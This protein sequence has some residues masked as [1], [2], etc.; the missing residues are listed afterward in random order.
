MTKNLARRAG[1][2]LIW[3]GLAEAAE[4]TIFLARLFILARL[5]APE[6]F[7]L[8]AV[9]MVA[10]AMVLRL[11]DFGVVASLIHAPE[12][13]QRHLDTAWTISL[14][15]GI[16]IA[17]I[18]LL[19][20]PWIADAFGEP[21]ATDIIRA[22]SLTALLQA[23]ASIQVAKLNREL[24]FRGLAVIRLS[25]AIANTIVAIFLA[26]SLGVWAMVWGAIA[27]EFAFMLVSYFVAPYR[28]RFSMSDQATK[29]I[30]RFGRW[31]F[32]IGIISVAADSVIR[33]I[34]SSRLGIAELGLY[35]MAWRLAYLPV[36]LISELVNEV[37]FPVYAQLQSNRDKAAAAFRGLLV[38]VAAIMVPTCVVF[39]W[40]VPEL[41]QYV[42]GERWQGTVEVMQLL[43]MT[44]IVMLLADGMVPVLKGLGQPSKIAAMDT[45]QLVILAALGWW[46]IGAWE[47]PGAGIAWMISILAA[48]VM[49]ARYA[50]EVFRTPFAGLLRPL[51]AIAAVSILAAIVAEAAKGLIPGLIGLGVAIIAA[52]LTAGA[53]TLLLDRMFSLGILQTVLVPFPW[54]RRLVSVPGEREP[55]R[56]G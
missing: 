43:I 30:A 20:A 46:L 41:V 49:A 17:A 23:A 8:L 25:A 55:R 54:I 21:R 6:D 29:S 15:R 35:F 13:G 2:G 56:E 31:I 50:Y 48:Q 38:S 36:Q 10:L 5:L 16:G 26:P 1:G 14:L 7:G 34:I 39:A 37:A 24:R 53:G 11:T 32:L 45:L 33:W 3:R 51:L 18:L 12:T 44:S 40:L 52:A 4:K 9:G 22:L 47:L 27:G 28:P 19:A 42:L